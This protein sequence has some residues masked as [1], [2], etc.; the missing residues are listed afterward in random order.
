MTKVR[1]RSGPI[2]QVHTEKASNLPRAI[3]KEPIVEVVPRGEALLTFH[4]VPADTDPL[5]PKGRE[6]GREIAKVAALD[7]ATP[8]EGNRVEKGH[9]RTVA[10]RLS[11]APWR[12]RLIVERELWGDI[13]CLHVGKLAGYQLPR[14]QLS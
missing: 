14:V 6:L 12:P 13:A 4:R 3:R 8:R 5:C 7:G 2:T 9:H 11:E 10:K 1:R